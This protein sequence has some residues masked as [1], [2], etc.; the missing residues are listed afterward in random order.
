[1]IN[2]T[3]LS[4]FIDIENLNLDDQDF[5]YQYPPENLN[6]ADATKWVFMVPISYIFPE[7]AS[8]SQNI[9][10]PINCKKVTFPD[11]KIGTSSVGYMGYKF[12]LNTGQ[13]LTEKGLTITYIVNS[14]WLQYLLLL[15]WF[16]KE[17]RTPYNLSSKTQD[18]PQE[19]NAL[20][21]SY[22]KK[23][24]LIDNTDFRTP[25]EDGTDITYSPYGPQIPCYLYLLDN[26]NRRI[27]TVLFQH[28][29]LS[30]VKAVS[31][32]QATTNTEVESSFD[33]KFAKYSITINDEYLKSKIGNGISPE[34]I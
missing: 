8:I 26:F 10:V 2:D 19:T 21:N 9:E 14:N 31:L 15:K 5:Q 25:A 4:G 33:L 13:N 11:F 20:E 34:T 17:D 32:D 27:C 29:W 30:T 3:N 28:C 6:L 22:T 18:A 12:D 7:M 24:I 1:M 23:G 16:E